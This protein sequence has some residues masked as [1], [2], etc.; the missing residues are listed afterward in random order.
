M[1]FSFL[2]GSLDLI[3][4]RDGEGVE[5]ARTIE[6]MRQ[7]TAAVLSLGFAASL[8][9]T[10]GG[11]DAQRPAAAVALD[12]DDIGGVVNG[13]RGPEAGVWVIAETSGLPTKYTKIVV[14]DDKGRFVI[15]GL[16][17]AT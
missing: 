12:G 8:F 7:R 6:N 3:A 2:R 14:T 15:P 17:R 4:A 10:F 16:P 13:P 5:R 1:R 11:V 9:A